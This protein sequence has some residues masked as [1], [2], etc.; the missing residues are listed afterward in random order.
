MYHI[1][2]TKRDSEACCFTAASSGLQV[3]TKRRLSTM[4]EATMGLSPFLQNVDPNIWEVRACAP[5]ACLAR[6]PAP[7]LRSVRFVMARL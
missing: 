4:L 3:V 7:L 1:L 2:C 5:A 6:Q